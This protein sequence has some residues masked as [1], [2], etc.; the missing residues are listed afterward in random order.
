LGVGVRLGASVGWPQERVKRLSQERDALFAL[1]AGQPRAD[2]CESINRA[3][4]FF[5]KRAQL[6]ELEALRELRDRP[7]QQ[8]IQ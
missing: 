1:I 3:N 8:L 4:A 7:D 5:E 6:G 2:S